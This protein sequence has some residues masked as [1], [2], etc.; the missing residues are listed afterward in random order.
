M[1]CCTAISVELAGVECELPRY[2]RDVS[3]KVVSMRASRRWRLAPARARGVLLGFD[4]L[5]LSDHHNNELVIE[6]L[7]TFTRLPKIFLFWI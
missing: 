6:T 4:F 5:F 7:H 2:G 3:N 1:N